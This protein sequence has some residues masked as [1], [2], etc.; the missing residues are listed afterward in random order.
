MTNQISNQSIIPSTDVIQLTLSLKMTTAQVV[1]TS[2]NVNY[3]S[4]I[5]D[6]FEMTPEFKP[7]TVMIII[8]IIVIITII[9]LLAKRV[10]NL[11][12]R[13]RTS[14]AWA[15][16]TPRQKVCACASLSI[17]GL[18]FSHTLQSDQSFPRTRIHCGC[19]LWF[20]CSASCCSCF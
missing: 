6:T 8:T 9:K 11:V 10:Y 17:S 18:F 12:A 3:N 4:P 5:Q 7:F 15:A 20:S 19:S 2:V 1:E 14:I 16:R 13:E